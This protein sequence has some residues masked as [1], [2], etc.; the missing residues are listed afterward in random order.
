[1]KKEMATY[2]SSL[3]SEEPGRLQFMVSQKSQ[4]RLSNLNN[5]NGSYQEAGRKEFL[6][7]FSF[8]K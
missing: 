3:A 1:M 2:S 8:S 6:S 7:S 5:S 4:T